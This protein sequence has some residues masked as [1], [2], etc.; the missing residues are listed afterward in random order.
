MEQC[1]SIFGQN[2]SVASGGSVQKCMGTK[3]NVLICGA[4][5]GRTPLQLTC[6]AEIHILIKDKKMHLDAGCLLVNDF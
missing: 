3:I 5:A 1:Q 6:A 4:P 2:L